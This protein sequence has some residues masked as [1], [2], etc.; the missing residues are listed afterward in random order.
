MAFWIQ[1]YRTVLETY[2]NNYSTFIK[3][4]LMN[5]SLRLAIWSLLFI[6]STFCSYSVNDDERIKK[7][8]IFSSNVASEKPITDW[9]KIN[10]KAKE[11]LSFCTKNG[12]NRD[13]CILIDMSIHSG[14]NRFF[15]WNFDSMRVEKE[16]LVSHGCC[17]L[18]WTGDESKEK[19]TFSNLNGS[20]CTSLGKYL[21]GTRGVSQFGVKIKY[22]LNGL[23]L[24]N[25]NAL[26]RAIVFHSWE[27][28]SDEEVYPNGTPEGWGCP[29][30]SDV[31]FIEMDQKLKKRKNVLLWIFD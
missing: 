29:A 18:P 23:E 16:M 17:D 20:H 2:Q 4:N 28:I 12:Y 30:I 3:N 21:I 14:L 9:D 24:G 10:R 8:N 1:F 22:L 19:P 26:E 25:K 31:N 13:F 11:A 15:V 7:E 6:M 5:F 27:L